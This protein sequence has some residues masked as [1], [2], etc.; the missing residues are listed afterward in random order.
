MIKLQKIKK[1]LYRN[2]PKW[3]RPHTWKDEPL[4]VLTI[5]EWIDKVFY[6]EE[7]A[8]YYLEIDPR[9]YLRIS[10]E[11]GFLVIRGYAEEDEVDAST[12][13]E[14][15]YKKEFA[16]PVLLAALTRIGIGY[17]LNANDLDIL[18]KLDDEDGS[19]IKRIISA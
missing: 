15:P 5:R 10:K 11:N 18:S 4:L 12:F 7:E 8:V 6:L 17:E 9:R 3:L 16:G 2:Y 13:F 1:K 14:V 19:F